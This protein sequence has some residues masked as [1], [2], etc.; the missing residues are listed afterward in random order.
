MIYKPHDYQKKAE[1]FLIGHPVAAL[2]LQMGLG[3]TVVTL[4]AL[5][6]LMFDY[7][8]AGKVLIIAPLRVARDTWKEEVEKWDHLKNLKLSVMVGTEKERRAALNR[9][10]NIY[11]INRENVEWL[12]NAMGPAF[13]FDT[14]VI[15]E[16]SSFKSYSSK[17]F[18]A[19]MKVRPKVRRIIGLTGTPASNGLMDLFAEF[20]V[21]DM[22]ERLGRFIGCYREEYFTPDKRNQNVIFS[23]KL[24][25][26]A[27]ERIYEKISDI[28][29]SMKALD[30][31]KM[32]EKVENTITVH[33]NDEEAKKYKELKDELV[34]ELQGEE[35]TALTAGSLAAK[36]MQAASGVVYKEG[37]S[38]VAFHE[39][40]LD[41]LEERIE[42]LNGQSALVAYWF[43][44]DK[45]RIEKLLKKMKVSYSFLD[46]SSGIKAWKDKK[47]QVGLIHPASA[48]HGLNIQSGGSTLIWYTVPW[49]LELYEQ[50]VARLWRQGQKDETVVIEHLVT[51]GTIDERIL[52][53]IG[54]KE[55][56]QSSLMDAVKADLGVKEGRNE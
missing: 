45:E 8:E 33:M 14:V 11:I 13:D 25:P 15:D 36:L 37:G 21:L 5:E 26:G 20:N 53:A 9:K 55:I 42:A 32:P 54:K 43:R 48:G 46:T 3:K 10:A 40:K 41:A 12:V 51:A 24:K 50:T 29:I 56:T 1:E 44:F 28:T 16:L 39:R 22:G 49:S 38:F 17:R 31:L 52:K 19:L 23:Y 2:F 30:Y 6:R 4:T 47:V 18:R 35:V 34:V 27:E 7:F